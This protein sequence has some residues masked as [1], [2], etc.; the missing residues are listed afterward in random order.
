[1]RGEPVRSARRL[2]PAK[3]AQGKQQQ[4]I[5]SVTT[6]LQIPRL[7]EIKLRIQVPSGNMDSSARSELKTG[8]AESGIETKLPISKCGL[9]HA[10]LIDVRD[11]HA[12]ALMLVM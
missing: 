1:M 6:F 7:S 9:L 8:L 12:G 11:S 10:C 5:P 3:P 2:P 4:R